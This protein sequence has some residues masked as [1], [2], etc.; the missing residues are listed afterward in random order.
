MVLD[1]FQDT[2]NLARLRAQ[3]LHPARKVKSHSVERLLVGICGV[4]AQDAFAARLAIWARTSSIKKSHIEAALVKEKSIVRTWCMRGTL[5]LLAASDLGWLLPIMGP[6]QIKKSQRRYKELDLTVETWDQALGAL[7]NILGGGRPLTRAE[8]ANRMSEGGIPIEGHRIYHILRR[9]ALE[10]VICCGPDREAEPTY[11]LLADW[12]HIEKEGKNGDTLA[13]LARR[14]LSAYGPAQP[15]DMAVWSGIPP[16]EARSA[17]EAIMGELVEL[18]SNGSRLWTLKVHESW[19]DESHNTQ[20]Y[21]RLLPA[22]DPCLLGYR[23]RRLIVPEQHAKRIHPG[24]GIIRPTLLVSGKDAG[25]WKRVKT[26]SGLEIKVEP[27]Q[28]L[29]RE[30]KKLLTKEV[31]RLGSFLGLKTTLNVEEPP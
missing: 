29:N 8:I 25:I 20:G 28:D 23:S 1:I 16:R 12:V 5:H 7:R 11:V 19:L 18:D 4:Q 2:V 27:F 3:R 30:T 14:Y 21:V 24:G 31:S 13:E 10:G 17:F 26:K 6:L 22:F 15:E 9:T